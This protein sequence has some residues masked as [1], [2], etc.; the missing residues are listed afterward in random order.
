MPYVKSYVTIHKN[1]QHITHRPSLMDKHILKVSNQATKEKDIEKRFEKNIILYTK[2]SKQVSD[3]PTIDLFKV[4]SLFS[5]H[6]L[7]G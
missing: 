6:D 5:R 1:V 7:A 2:T 4:N 3:T